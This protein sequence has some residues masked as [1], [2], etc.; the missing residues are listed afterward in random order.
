MNDDKWARFGGGREASEMIMQ[1]TQYSRCSIN[2]NCS[3]D[4]SPSNLWSQ[5]S[6][7]YLIDVSFEGDWET[8]LLI[9]GFDRG[10]AF[11]LSCLSQ[12]VPS[13][14]YL[15]LPPFIPL[16]LICCDFPIQTLMQASVARGHHSDL[17]L[18]SSLLFPSSLSLFIFLHLLSLVL[19][20]VHILQ[21]SGTFVC[22]GISRGVP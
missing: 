10:D 22:V 14:S 9:G 17:W 7:P 18:A 2:C 12:L 20:S 11:A 19:L 3:F 21:G 6:Y 13:C 8:W 16:F 5:T 1:S 15:T 4:E